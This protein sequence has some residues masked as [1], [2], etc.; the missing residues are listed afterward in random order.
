MLRRLGVTVLLPGV[1]LLLF[2]LRALQQDQ[3][4]FDREVRDRL[5]NASAARAI[6]QQL[7]NWQTGRRSRGAIPAGVYLRPCAVP[8]IQTTVRHERNGPRR[9]PGCSLT[10]CPQLGGRKSRNTSTNRTDIDRFPDVQ[11]SGHL[12]GIAA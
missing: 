7:L 10:V 2:G 12:A 5:E 11:G 6:D 8:V 1:I 4:S 3:R 9:A